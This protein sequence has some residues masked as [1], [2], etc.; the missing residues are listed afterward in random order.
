LGKGL[1][2]ISRVPG[3]DCLGFREKLEANDFCNNPEMAEGQFI[4]EASIASTVSL[5]IEH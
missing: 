1:E 4:H 2:A 5:F 3:G